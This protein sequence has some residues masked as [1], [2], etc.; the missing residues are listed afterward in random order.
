L[1]F[2]G[3]DGRSGRSVFLSGDKVGGS[4]EGDER[5][6]SEE[7]FLSHCKNSKV[8]KG[9]KIPTV[10]SVDAT[11]RDFSKKRSLKSRRQN[12]KLFCR[13]NKQTSPKIATQPR[14]QF[15]TQ[16]RDASINVRNLIFWFFQRF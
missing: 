2:D 16:R 7:Q 11:R 6:E 10:Q 12:D 9:G 14:K 15:G 1:S 5:D 8:L 3:G 13:S 4:G